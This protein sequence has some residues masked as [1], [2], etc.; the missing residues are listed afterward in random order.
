MSTAVFV[1]GYLSG[2]HLHGSSD[3]AGPP[4]FACPLTARVGSGGVV[5]KWGEDNLVKGIGLVFS[6]VPRFDSQTVP[7]AEA[8]APVV[9]INSLDLR[10]G[11]VSNW[12]AD[13]SYV[14]KNCHKVLEV[15]PGFK[16][17]PIA[18]R[19]GDVWA[20]LK[21]LLCEGKMVLPTKVS[22]HLPIE[23]VG[24]SITWHQFILNGIA[25]A[26]AD[27]A[28]TEFA[29][30]ATVRTRVE[31][32]VSLAFKACMRIAIV[33][34]EHSEYL[35]HHE[36]SRVFPR[37]LYCPTANEAVLFLHNRVASNGHRLVQVGGQIEC[38]HCYTKVHSRDFK[39]FEECTC[40]DRL[41]M[42][43]IQPKD[44][45][46]SGP[47]Y[48]GKGLHVN[49]RPRLLSL[50]SANA[51]VSKASLSVL[52]DARVSLI[53]R[54]PQKFHMQV[55]TPGSVAAQVKPD[56]PVWMLSLHPSHTLW[57]AGG[58]S[59]CSVCGLLS[60]GWSKNS[61]LHRV[62]GSKFGKR[63]GLDT[64]APSIRRLPA[65]SEGRLRRL[66]KGKLPWCFEA[67][68]N[69]AKKDVKIPPIRL[70][71][72]KR[73]WSP[74]VSSAP[75]DLPQASSASSS[76]SFA[77]VDVV[78]GP[79]ICHV[80]RVPKRPF[81]WLEDVQPGSE[82]TVSLPQARPKRRIRGKQTL[83]IEDARV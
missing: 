63:K 37:T 68:P 6:S 36:V 60:S 83:A 82:D 28:V 23:A 74:A 26:L 27:K 30:P 50:A 16:Q 40:S 81:F 42:P 54:L 80:P 34:K 14:V 71:P 12:D 44:F 77:T 75:R 13:A 21:D 22:S 66:T 5:V 52:K 20:S 55:S 11:Q 70:F 29:L 79:S 73:G 57:Q 35:K 59:F 25:D 67:W 58:I 47:L 62:C 48:V 46:K 61:N 53:D 9:T 17:G 64:S 7:R 51:V 19:H 2:V 65:G 3:G 49:L 24:T 43:S 18:G 38:L 32:V 15:D 33:E 1:D 78:A 8:W 72:N 56:T 45:V 31:D 4:R 10:M 76:S 69:G 41:S 39:F